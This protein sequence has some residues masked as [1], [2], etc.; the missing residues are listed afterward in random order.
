LVRHLSDQ[1]G[2][3]CVQ[4]LHDLNADYRRERA[5]EDRLLDGVLIALN[6]VW[7]IVDLPSLADTKDPSAVTMQHSVQP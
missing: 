7:Q 5:I 2:K 4:A 1:L 6:T 3:S